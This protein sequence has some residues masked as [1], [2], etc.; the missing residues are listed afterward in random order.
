MDSLP[1]G[2][3]TKFVRNIK[4]TLSIYR[5]CSSLANVQ[6]FSSFIYCFALFLPVVLLYFESLQ[7]HLYLYL[8]LEYLKIH[9]ERN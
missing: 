2:S 8:T 6:V 4:A 1:V 3:Q 7:T 9:P 5:I